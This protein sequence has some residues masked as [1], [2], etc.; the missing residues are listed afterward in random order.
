M[1]ISAPRYFYGE[2]RETH[3][4]FF[5]DQRCPP[6]SAQAPPKLANSKWF[7][8]LTPRQQQV[9]SYW[10]T[11]CQDYDM[12]D[13]SQSIDRIFKVSEGSPCITPKAFFFLV[14]EL[15]VLVGYEHML[16]Q[17]WPRSILRHT[18]K[19][20]NFC[21][22]GL[23]RDLAGNSYCISSIMAVLV[24]VFVSLPFTLGSLVVEDASE[25][26][27]DDVDALMA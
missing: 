27:M 19:T 5:A 18:L 6:S 24:A 13:V 11:L 14:H 4:R 12:I 1:R 17:G 21:T 9:L 25:S 26:E 3:N 15:R 2:W 7:Q 22:D 8:N 23:F 16:L 20:Y 10:I